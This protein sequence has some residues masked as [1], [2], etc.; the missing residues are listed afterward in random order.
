METAEG[1][2]SRGLLSPAR[3]RSEGKESLSGSHERVELL[4]ITPFFSLSFRPLLS[5]P[6][7]ILS[8]PHRMAAALSSV[9]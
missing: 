5:P 8:T 7:K 9:A 3:S 6:P 1:A 2:P 4:G